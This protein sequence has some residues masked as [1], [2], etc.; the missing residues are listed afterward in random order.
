MPSWMPVTIYATAL[1]AYLA[2]YSWRHMDDSIGRRPFVMLIF[3]TVCSLLADFYGRLEGLDFIPLTTL[4]GA[5]VINFLLFPALGAEWHQ[6]IRNILTAEERLRMRYIGSFVTVVAGIGIVLSMLSPVTSW[7]FYYDAA[8]HYQ[9]GPLFLA[10]MITT[11]L[12]FVVT[13]IFLFTQVKSLSRYSIRMLGAYPIAVVIGSLLT[14]VIDD[15]P[16]IP[17]GFS[18]STLGLFA[19]MQNTGMGRDYLTGLYNRRKLEELMEEYIERT[20]EGRKFAAIMMDLDNF[21][22]INDTLGH[23]TGDVALSETARLLKRSV[24]SGDAVAR[25]GGDEFF[26]L[27]DM[28]AEDSLEDIIKRIENEEEAFSRTD[29]RYELRLSKGY[30]FFDAN[31]FS[32]VREFET[33]LDNL[34]YEDKK[35]RHAEYAARGDL[36]SARATERGERERIV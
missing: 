19:H 14:F 34:M 23:T 15:V 25:F 18:I 35:R 13:D 22:R 27:L 16:W 26:I 4:S 8:G 2:F 21:K 20:E 36:Y 10:P 1:L 5:T 6:F 3:L 30:D 9:R 31:K 33:H 7:V 17:L 12:I 29:G 11:L 24:R 32:S 28:D